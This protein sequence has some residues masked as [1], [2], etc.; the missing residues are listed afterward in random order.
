MQVVEEA[1]VKGEV[2]EGLSKSPAHAVKQSKK[3][4]KKKKKKSKKNR[5][6][7][8]SCAPTTDKKR[9]GPVVRG[10]FLLQAAPGCHII[11][12]IN[13]PKWIVG[14][15]TFFAED[16]GLSSDT[17]EQMPDI[18]IDPES[19]LL[20][21][22]NKH[23]SNIRT[24]YI[25]VSCKVLDAD[26]KDMENGMARDIDG[27]AFSC[28]TF[29]VVLPPQALIDIC[30]LQ[31][32][33][34]HDDNSDLMD[35]SVY[36]LY[37][38]VQD[39]PTFQYV[40][41]LLNS[42][43]YSAVNMLKAI[44]EKEKYCNYTFP[45]KVFLDLSKP[46]NSHSNSDKTLARSSNSSRHG[47]DPILCSQGFCGCFT[48]F[49]QATRHAIDLECPV[50][51]PILAVADGTVVEVKQDNV[52]SGIHA[53]NLYKWNSIM[54]KL[55]DGQ[56]V[57]YV[58]IETNS[59]MVKVGDRVQRG[60]HICNSG[61]VGFCPRPHLHIQMHNSDKKDAPTIPFGFKRCIL[62]PNAMHS[63]KAD[64]S[65]IE[66]LQKSADEDDAYFIPEAGKFYT[67]YGLYCA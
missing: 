58:H 7:I 30:Y 8:F 42:V 3:N 59:V 53:S 28:V 56:F 14:M 4:K 25:S 31:R 36:K 40:P 44:D 65:A 19:G 62:A 50:S 63:S 54:L 37:S 55:D 38:D 5:G 39:I 22:V 24:F 9:E 26:L 10:N 47:I 51:T 49:F 20:T 2:S 13:P 6:K 61:D 16:F 45:F 12:G 23:E 29:V 57:E 48:H 11:H 17:V 64:N 35:N 33:L 66:D 15:D 32:P 1:V 60:Q 67:E 21:C 18:S 46:T 27:K 41:P 52:V 34:A 43:S